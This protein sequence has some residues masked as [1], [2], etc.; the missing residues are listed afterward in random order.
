LWLSLDP[1]KDLEPGYCDPIHVTE[2][3]W[4]DGAIFADFTKDDTPR[5]FRLGAFADRKVW[6]P[7]E[8]DWNAVPVPERPMVEVAKPP[9]A[10]GQWT[11][12]VLT[13]AGFNSGK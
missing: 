4:N 6:D 12:V 3:G 13:W 9:F 8:R 10:R 11:H 2:R 7:R 1:E 5:H